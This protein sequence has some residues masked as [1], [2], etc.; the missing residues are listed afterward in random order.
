MFTKAVIKPNTYSDSMV[1]MA[2]STKVNELPI[3][4]K[5]M[6]GMATNLN[7]Q[8]AFEVGLSN[9]EIEAATPRDQIIVVQCETEE[10][11]D[12]ALEMVEVLRQ[13]GI[14][15]SGESAYANSRAAFE[16]EEDSSLVIISVPGEYAAK[17]AQKALSVNKNV[18]IFSDN[19]TVEE[20][21]ALKTYAHEHELLVMGP[22]CGTAII[23]GVGLCFANSVN[24]GPIGV[25]GASGTG[26]QE[27]SV[28]IHNLGSGISQLIGIG[29]RDLSE[30]I[31]GIMMLDAMNMLDA[32]PSTE[33]ILLLS[34]PPAKI[35]AEKV[36]NAAARLSKPVVVCFIGSAEAKG[37]DGNITFTG[38][39][40][41]AARE[42]V[43][44]SNGTISPYQ[45]NYDFNYEQIRTT[46]KESQKDI[47][48][49][50]CGGTVCDEVFHAVRKSRSNTFSNIAKDPAAKLAVHEPEHDNCLIDL[51]SDEYT[52]GRPH[53]M[54]DP[55]LRNAEIIR[56][57]K[58]AKTAVLV[59]DFEL[60]Y[61]SHSDP[62]GAALDTI[63]EAQTLAASEG[64]H[65]A[66]VAYVLGTE[67]DPQ[68][69]KAQ[70]AKL[71]E[72]GVLVVNA[73][74][75]LAEVALELTK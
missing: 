59:L 45:L 55:T 29:G 15:D 51:G 42:A 1:L 7:K 40:L 12:E 73:A 56:A 24:R 28:Q 60:G 26:S 27:V 14:S 21:L 64:R 41:Y 18:M 74:I 72:L 17:E 2:L 53:P 43:R 39:T 4:H 20:E 44:L 58:D 10:L 6:V 35:V 5:A 22:D 11:C 9:A 61:G 48:G 19:V 69:K 32:D 62:V 50:F 57:A 75:D 66:I 67:T 25:V 68:D 63:K 71:E 30:E 33:V 34:K 8:V 47:R 54:I 65:L 23:N 3:V 70:V 37:T 49:L 13:Q 31:G 46:F 38:N 16:A 52:Q 36:L